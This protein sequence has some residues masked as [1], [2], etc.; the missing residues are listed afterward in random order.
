MNIQVS[1]VK[2]MSSWN[3]KLRFSFFQEEKK[4]KETGNKAT[5]R[6]NTKSTW[7]VIS[8]SCRKKKV[9]KPRNNKSEFSKDVSEVWKYMD[10][11][12]FRLSKS[13]HPRIRTRS[14]VGG[15]AG[16]LQRKSRSTSDPAQSRYFPEVCRTRPSKCCCSSPTFRSIPKCH[17]AWRQKTP[18]KLERK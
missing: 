1:F 6:S 5:D 9:R 18:L 15:E 3:V 4:V 8:K 7:F 14:S 13:H 2:I 11:N 17:S 16:C 12:H 10:C